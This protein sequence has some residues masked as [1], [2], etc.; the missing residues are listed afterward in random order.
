MV[1]LNYCKSIVT[2][3][4]KKAAV[5]FLGAPL[6]GPHFWSKD[7]LQTSVYYE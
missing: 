3:V 7:V 1:S 4:L 5:L 2:A 6:K